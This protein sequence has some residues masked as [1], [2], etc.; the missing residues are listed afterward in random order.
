MVPRRES[1]HS[2]GPGAVRFGSPAATVAT[3]LPWVVVEAA[4]APFVVN[5]GTLDDTEIVRRLGPTA[6]ASADLVD[7][8]FSGPANGLRVEVERSFGRSLGVWWWKASG[9]TQSKVR[10]DGTQMPPTRSFAA[11]ARLAVERDE[12]ILV[13]PFTDSVRVS[14]DPCGGRVVQ[15]LA[16]R[17]PIAC[18]VPLGA[19]K[20]VAQYRPIQGVSKT[21]FMRVFP[22]FSRDYE[23][24]RRL[25]LLVPG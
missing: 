11:K 22:E 8:R 13:S 16:Q 21:Y 9:K 10:L 1:M 24:L 14:I 17:T 19:T 23:A 20:G 5:A 4:R 18:L 3:R 2:H 25:P 6:L 12:L 15:A 7:V